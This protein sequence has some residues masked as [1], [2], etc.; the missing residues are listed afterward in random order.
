LVGIAGLLMIADLLCFAW[1]KSVQCDPSLYFPRIPALEQV[2]KSEPGRVIGYN[3]LPANVASMAGLWDVRG[4]DAVDPARIVDLLA[5][6]GNARSKPTYALTQ[7]L[8]PKVTSIPGGGIRLLPL[9]DILNVRYVIVRGSPK[10]G[11]KPIF[12]SPDYWVVRNEFALPR[13]YIPKT[14]KI[15]TNTPELLEKLSSPT[16]APRNE[17]Y[18]DSSLNLNVNLTPN[19]NLPSPLPS[20]GPLLTNCL[21][22]ATLISETS[23]RVTL[24]IR[25][26][27][28]GLVVLADAWDKGWRTYLNGKPVPILRANHALR[29]VVV[30]EGNGTL[31]FR[32][33]PASFRLGLVL[34]GL[35]VAIMAAWV[36]GSA[37]RNRR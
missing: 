11:T 26:E 27:T 31:E 6:S 1:G 37:I 17:A 9:L 34:A 14:V 29:G 32:Y 18:L 8:A 19:L 23:T 3:C 7:K 5:L 15:E 25:M 20:G 22:T 10:P 2:A 12:Q 24:S 4:Y 13:A 35:A 16:F 36:A 30:P 21:G 28:P 33:E